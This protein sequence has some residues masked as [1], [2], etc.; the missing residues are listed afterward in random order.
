[1]DIID[2]LEQYRLERRITQPELAKQV[3]VA[4]ATINR[5]LTRKFKPSKIQQYHVDKFLNE[6]TKK[7]R[8]K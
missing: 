8:Q 1:M 7:A 5:W 4:Y 3:G 6:R 2:R